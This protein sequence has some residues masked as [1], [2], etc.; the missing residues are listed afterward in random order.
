MFSFTTHLFT[1]FVASVGVLGLTP[2]APSSAQSGGT[3]TITWSS[4][5]TD[6]TFSI[7]LT[8]P[9]FNA[10]I[11]IA[12]NVD[13][14]N[15]QVT[16][17]L[18]IVPADSDYTLQFVNI[19]DINQVFATSPD[20]SIAPA[21]STSA[22][23]S[24]ATATMPTASTNVG[25]ST[26]GASTAGAS[27]GASVITP[28]SSA[29]ASAASGAS[30]VSSAASTTGSGFPTSGATRAFAPLSGL[31]LGIGPVGLLAGAWLL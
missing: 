1:L 30:A 3:V 16:V 23:A 10:A 9:S 21:P 6:P 26:N 8:H 17:G 22:S 11:A 12:N 28:L 24:T 4:T 31:G 25:A 18:P 5:A 27:T 19:T 14:L 15:N 2:N 7:E 20:F 29:P 13:P